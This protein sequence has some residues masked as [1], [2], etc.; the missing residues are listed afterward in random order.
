MTLP[1]LSLLLALI[2]AGLVVAGVLVGGD[3]SWVE[4]IEGAYF[5]R[6]AGTPAY[7]G[8]FSAN[9]DPDGPQLL[10]LHDG[11]LWLGAGIALLIAATGALIAHGVGLRLVRVEDA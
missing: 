6:A 3:R 2:G 7:S 1:R 9:F 10:S 5:T 8:V 11:N 4:G